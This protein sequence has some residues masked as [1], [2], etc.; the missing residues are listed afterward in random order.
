[1]HPSQET[2]EIMKECD[3]YLSRLRL[4]IDV[5]LQK[6]RDINQNI[7]ND[8]IWLLKSNSLE[9]FSL[10]DVR[11]IMKYDESTF[12]FWSIEIVS[13]YHIKW[14]MNITLEL[15]YLSRKRPI[16][17]TKQCYFR[18]YRSTKWVVDLLY[19][20]TAQQYEEFIYSFNKR[21]REKKKTLT[22]ITHSLNRLWTSINSVGKI[23]SPT[24]VLKQALP[25]TN[26]NK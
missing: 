13:I 14:W 8:K 16:C 2:E 15:V 19:L 6:L 3:E 10:L 5:R 22:T 11:Q 21:I 24:I 18:N 25:N 4:S 26:P 23:N 9:A 17:W 20:Q 1:M 12:E 7:N